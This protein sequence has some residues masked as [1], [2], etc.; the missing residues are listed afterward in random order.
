M[1]VTAV[2]VAVEC[3]NCGVTAIY[4][5]FGGAFML[6]CIFLGQLKDR[7]TYETFKTKFLKMHR[8]CNQCSS[9]T[10]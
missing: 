5:G 10:V 4:E 2:T 9:G 8:C 7:L 1:E 6:L 3:Q